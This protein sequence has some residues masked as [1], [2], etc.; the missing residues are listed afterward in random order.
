MPRTRQLSLIILAFLAF[1]SLGMPE[2]LLGVAWPFM[3]ADFHQPLDSLGLILIFF[4]SGYLVSSFFSGFTVRLLGVGGLLA[5]SVAA[6]A[7]ALLAYTF[8]PAWWL[9]IV[10]SV[11]LGAGAGAIDAGLN[12]YIAANHSDG[13]MQWLHACFGV[14]VTLGPL[15]MTLGLAATDTW[16]A[17]YWIVG[18]LQLGLAMAFFFTRHLWQLT[19]EAQAARAA[20]QAQEHARDASFRS[21]FRQR[22][23]WLSMSLFF[24]YAGLEITLGLWAF[25]LLTES[26]GLATDQA[27][28][29]VSVYWGMFTVGRVCAGL[30]A[31]RFGVDTVIGGSLAL[32]FIAALLV[33]WN[34]I[35]GIGLAGV[36]LAGFAYAPIFPAMVS[37]TRL[38]LPRTHV[39]NTMGMQFAAVGLGAAALPSLAGAI[40]ARTSLEVIGPFLV[41]VTL[42]L[43]GLYVLIR[44]LPVTTAEAA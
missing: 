5:L 18:A 36:V 31:R 30:Y 42:L 2:G 33:W 20:E 32:A 1:I 9:I 12:N 17:G 13:L 14:G 23:A 38:R 11:L 25:S 8:A 19:P 6:T 26:R 35:P 7:G 3:R 4:T 41:V 39:T 43:S 10:V 28:I 22:N 44:V 16:R 27:A 29:W 21:T 15:L 34:P 40:A 24:V 37:G